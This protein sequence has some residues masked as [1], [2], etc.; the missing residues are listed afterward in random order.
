MCDAGFTAT[1]TEIDVKIFNREFQFILT[2]TSNLQNSL[3]DIRVYLL[4]TAIPSIHHANG[5]IRKKTNKID[6][7][8]Y[9][10]S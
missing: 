7:V 6:M 1:F 10:H 4:P 3:W 8:Q 9:H 5:I 2:G